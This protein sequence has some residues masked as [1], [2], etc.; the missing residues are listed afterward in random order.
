M[1]AGP[2]AASCENGPLMALKPLD[3]WLVSCLFLIM[4]AFYGVV[5]EKLFYANFIR[6]PFFGCF[7]GCCVRWF[8]VDMFLSMVF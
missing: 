5:F 6:G 1:A 8:F 2:K 3:F 4:F 7:Y